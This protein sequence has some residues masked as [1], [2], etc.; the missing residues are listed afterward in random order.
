MAIKSYSKNF[1]G[2]LPE[3]YKKRAYFLEVFG[4]VQAVDGVSDNE[5]YLILKTEDQDVVIQTYDTGTNVGFGTGT[6]KTSRF[7]NRREIKSKTTTVPYEKPLAIHEGIDKMTVND[8]FDEQIAKRSIKHAEAWTENVSQMLADNLIKEGTDI[9]KD[10]ITFKEIDEAFNQVSKEYV[11]LG[12]DTTHTWLVYVT[13]DVYQALVDSDKLTSVKG[14][15]VNLDRNEVN[16]YKGFVIFNTPDRFFADTPEA[17][18][19]RKAHM[20]FSVSG[21]G[22]VGVGVSTYR[23]IDS[24][25]FDGVAIQS[26]AKYGKYIP[27]DNK[28]VV[29]V[30]T[31]ASE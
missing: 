26:S 10:S 24:E 15:T 6:G 21:I 22:K 29:K 12:V 5:N 2:V 11:N 8:K 17:K 20:I 25:D 9:Q 28:K 3:V 18:S 16:M 4:T 30:V 23:A 19:G 13:P 7:G 31:T 1:I 27:E 14:S